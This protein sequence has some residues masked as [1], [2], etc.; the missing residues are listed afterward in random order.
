MLG[1]DEPF[2]HWRR[3]L[4]RWLDAH[5]LADGASRRFANDK[6]GCKA[7]IKWLAATAA[8]RV[9]FEPTGPYHRVLERALDAAGVPIA[10]VNPRQARRF[11]EAAGKLVK[12]D[13]ADAAM[14]A[15]MGE[16]LDLRPR[17]CVSQTIAELKEL[18]LARAALVKDHTADKNRAKAITLPLLEKQNKKRLAEIDVKIDEIDAAIGKLVNDDV[19]LARRFEILLSIPGVSKIT[20]FALL[21]EMPELG[22]LE[23]K[24]AATMRRF[25]SEAAPPL[26]S[27]RPLAL[28]RKR[29]RW[30]VGGASSGRRRRMSMPK[31]I[32]CERRQRL[33]SKRA[34][35]HR[36]TGNWRMVDLD[37][38]ASAA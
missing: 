35:A 29:L 5:R 10:R 30:P 17:P 32:F 28:R 6:A 27:S 36:R 8:A 19:Q 24:Q 34:S 22:T 13:R 9:V 18:H 1:L 11:A 7:L 12:T 31:M 26:R 33:S 2:Y 37:K 16:V 3:R 14:L 38:P 25:Q 23:G 15:R 20:A 4:E 21:I